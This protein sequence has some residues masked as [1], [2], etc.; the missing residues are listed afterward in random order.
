ME[1]EGREKR[2]T[3]SYLNQKSCVPQTRM[4]TPP[5]IFYMGLASVPAILWRIEN[6]NIFKLK[7]NYIEEF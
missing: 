3:T 7:E 2:N 5:L 1:R 6:K 4:H